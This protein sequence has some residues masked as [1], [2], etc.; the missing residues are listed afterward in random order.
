MRFL[1]TLLVYCIFPLPLSLPYCMTC[2][3]FFFAL[4]NKIPNEI[5]MKAVQC[6]RKLFQFVLS[7]MKQ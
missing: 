7:N 4:P 3:G 2:C 6:S 1:S 5:F